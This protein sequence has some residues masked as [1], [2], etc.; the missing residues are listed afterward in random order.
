MAAIAST[1]PAIAGEP[2]RLPRLREDLR[3]VEGPRHLDG[4]PSWRILDPVRNAF[5]EVGWLEFELLA[6]WR[7]HTDP[8][9][10]AAAV[11]RETRLDPSAGEV[12]ELVEFLAL[13]QLLMPDSAIAR[14]SLERR[15]R[16]SRQGWMTQAMHKYLFF[17]VP[18]FRPDGF[19]TRT[20][21][22][23]DIF[24]TRGFLLAIALIL[25]LDLY[26]LS[27]DWASFAEQSARMF[28][29][30]GMLYYAIAATLAKVLHELGHAYAAKR[31]GVRVPTMGV[32]FLILWPYLYTDTGE[33]WKLA[34]RGKQ[35][36]IA[37]AGMATEL[38]LAVV[39]TLLWALAP[40]GAVKSVLFVFAT[41]T[42][43]MTLAINASPF[44][45][46]DGYFVLSD[47]LDFPNLHDRSAACAKWWLRT[48]FFRL[49]E[50]MPEPTLSDRGRRWLIVF[51][52]VTWLY[53]FIIFIGIALLVYHLFF[54][55]LG[56][57]LFAVEIVYF[58]IMPVAREAI[59]VWE[60]RALVRL[61]WK[62]AAAALVLALIAVWLVPVARE[63]TAPAY[64]RGNFEHAV[65]A[66]FSGRVTN[67]EVRD[68]QLVEP[69]TVLLRVQMQDLAVR[70]R[71]AEVSIA[72]ARAELERMP[73]SVRQQE[74][75]AVLEEQLAEALAA[76]Q[77]VDEDA[78]R[79]LVRAD[80][81]GVVRDVATGLAE[82][83]WVNSRQLLLRVVSESEPLIIANVA[84]RQVSAI[85]PG[86][87]V[88]F[89]P[90][91]AE[92]AV[93]EGVVETIEAAPIREVGRLLMAS[94]HGGDIAVHANGAAGLP[95]A[96]EPFF[97][98]RIRPLGPLHVDQVVRGRVRV[99]TD[100]RL[101]AENF[102]YRALS[103]LIRESG[104]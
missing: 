64:V 3:L 7:D 11:A 17:R 48:T 30:Q 60:R 28:T 40:E 44:M 24:F 104:I 5:F 45:R 69:G 84:E 102:V 68:G 83:Q 20:A 103:L 47:A 27:R 38:A 1:S 9:S 77:A 55:L 22:L 71:K 65:Y 62:P 63:V 23:T 52:L 78:A 41:T 39:S 87:K 37:S 46:F 26:L 56:I 96:Q 35:L 81:A 25:G 16:L 99:Q 101:I 43:V 42:W 76:K 29:P 82:G 4:S 74:R 73:A 86:Q 19:L 6:R 75:R 13:N 93:I 57:L 88:F 8:G 98:V 50:E 2:P 72:S 80:Y 51:A 10:L 31:Y 49:P 32:A 59:Y 53:R 15:W 100:L 33:T 90:S 94:V 61:A 66:P 91:R 14:Q 89:Y 34:D 97:R 79:Q 58:V 92:L 70:A 21:G 67:V 36:V 95:Q 54:K 85:E 18:L 12:Q